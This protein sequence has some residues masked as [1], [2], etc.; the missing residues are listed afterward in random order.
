MKQE[1][2]QAEWLGLDQ[3]LRDKLK[4]IFAIN[5]SEGMSVVNGKLASDGCSQNDLTA[6]ITIGKM[7]NYTGDLKLTINTDE[8]NES[9]FDDLF[10]IVVAKASG[11]IKAIEFTIGAAKELNSN[12]KKDEETKDDKTNKGTEAE[13]KGTK[14]ESKGDKQTTGDGDNKSSGDDSINAGSGDR[15]DI[16]RPKT[17]NKSKRVGHTSGKGT[18]KSKKTR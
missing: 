7:I 10:E 16:Q 13:S 8:N 17:T 1:L 2:L 5:R 3:E 11:K 18:V 12:T 14:T 15:Q 9:L 6:G 4:E